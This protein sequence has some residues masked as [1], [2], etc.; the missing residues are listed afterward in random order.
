MPPA[1]DGLVPGPGDAAGEAPLQE[2]GAVTARAPAERPEKQ[3]PPV[4]AWREDCR[5]CGTEPQCTRNSLEA[6]APMTDE[7]LRAAIEDPAAHP[8][9]RG[10]DVR[11]ARCLLD[12]GTTSDPV[13]GGQSQARPENHDRRPTRCSPD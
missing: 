11:V 2:A 1:G 9:R 7:A 8:G 6:L 4:A 10:P 12:A 5:A 3:L 13:D